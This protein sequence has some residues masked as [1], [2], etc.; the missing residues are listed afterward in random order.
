MTSPLAGLR[1]VD[2]GVRVEFILNVLRVLRPPVIT[3]EVDLQEL[4]ARHFARS[5][6][7]SEREKRLGPHERI[8]F[9]MSATAQVKSR[10]GSPLKASRRMTT[11][12][13]RPP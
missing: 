8:D 2:V 12:V 7:P 4:I 13:S 3:E 11:R 9:S 6:I 5:G 1:D 10:S